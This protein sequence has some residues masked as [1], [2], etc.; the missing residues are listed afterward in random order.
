[1]EDMFSGV[2]TQ[3]T[4]MTGEIAVDFHGGMLSSDFPKNQGVDTR[5]YHVIAIRVYRE[6][7]DAN[8]LF[9]AVDMDKVTNAG[10]ENMPDYA[11]SNNGVLPVTVFHKFIP[12]A[13]VLKEIKR[14]HF[15]IASGIRYHSSC[16]YDP[17]EPIDL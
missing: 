10:F 7:S 13:D 4:D 12:V 6:D 15:Q 1:M 2:S 16:E 11:T 9:Y 14:F 17:A 3:V 8:V 5:R